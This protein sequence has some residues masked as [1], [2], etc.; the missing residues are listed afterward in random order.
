MLAHLGPMLGQLG[1]MLGQL[2]PMLAHLGPMLADLGA[3]VLDF[4]L[5]IFFENRYFDD[6]NFFEN[7]HSTEYTNTYKTIVFEMLFAGRTL[8]M[9]AN[10]T[11]FPNKTKQ[12][13]L[14]QQKHKKKTKN[15]ENPS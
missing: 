12:T 13:R 7:L 14:T 5:F 10:M 11:P 3:K 1:A 6:N 2:G 4:Q 8:E 15:S 9:R